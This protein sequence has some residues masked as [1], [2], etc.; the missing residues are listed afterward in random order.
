MSRRSGSRRGGG[1]LYVLT[2]TQP[3]GGGG[4][5]CSG[6]RGRGAR[7]AS[8]RAVLLR[9][10]APTASAPPK[11]AEPTRAASAPTAEHGTATTSL[12]GDTQTERDEDLTADRAGNVR[13]LGR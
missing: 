8:N 9:A 6:R 5:D 13:R 2:L 3:S 11:P 10:A 7:S 12:T 4:V 1:V